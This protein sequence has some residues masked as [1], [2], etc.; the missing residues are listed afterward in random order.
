M[1]TRTAEEPRRESPR[2]A[3]NNAE[4]PAPAAEPPAAAVAAAAAAGASP[5]ARPMD[6]EHDGKEPHNSNDE[7]DE[8]MGDDNDNDNDEEE[9]DNDNDNDKE[10]E[11]DMGPEEEEEEEEEELTTRKKTRLKGGCP[12][13]LG[14]LRSADGKPIVV[15]VRDALAEQYEG[16]AYEEVPERPEEK[17]LRE[18]REQREALAQ[19]LEREGKNKEQGGAEDAKR[20]DKQELEAQRRL[21]QQ[22]GWGM[23]GIGESRLQ[24]V[25][26]SLEQRLNRTSMACDPT[27]YYRELRQG[28]VNKVD[29]DFIDDSEQVHELGFDL[30]AE[31]E[32]AEKDRRERAEKNGN[33]DNG[34]GQDNDDDEGTHSETDEELLYDPSDFIFRQGSSDEESDSEKAAADDFQRDIDS[35]GQLTVPLWQ[36]FQQIDRMPFSTPTVQAFFADL[37]RDLQALE[38]TRDHLQHI[39]QKFGALAEAVL[40]ETDVSVLALH[41]DKAGKSPARINVWRNLFHAV[42]HMCPDIKKRQFDRLWRIDYLSEKIKMG[43]VF[44]EECEQHILSSEL[45][46]DDPTHRLEL[47]QAFDDFRLRQQAATANAKAA[48]EAPPPHRPEGQGEGEASPPAAAAPAG[49]AGAGDGPVPMEIDGAASPE[50]SPS[51]RQDEASPQGSPTAAFPQTPTAAANKKRKEPALTASPLQCI[52]QW[53]VKLELIHRIIKD[54]Y[55]ALEGEDSREAARLQLEADAKGTFMQYLKKLLEPLG[56]MTDRPF[57][58]TNAMLKEHVQFLKKQFP[59]P[60]PARPKAKA[61][62]RTVRQGSRAAVGKR[63]HSGDDVLP[64]PAHDWRHVTLPS[65]AP[66]LPLTLPMQVEIDVVLTD[67][68]QEAKLTDVWLTSLT[69]SCDDVQVI[70]KDEQWC[71]GRPPETFDSLQEAYTAIQGAFRGVRGV[72]LALPDAIQPWKAFR[73]GGFPHWPLFDVCVLADLRHHGDDSQTDQQN[74]V[75]TRHELTGVPFVH[76]DGDTGPVMKLQLPRRVSGGG[77]GVGRPVPAKKHKKDWPAASG[78]YEE[79]PPFDPQ[80]FVPVGPVESLSST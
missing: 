31:F 64:G 20:A 80:D 42:K 36:H 13:Y 78:Q 38:D 27:S 75:L 50:P 48:P 71:K 19:Q 14:P 28:R 24:D 55:T 51:P 73:L 4:H 58:L 3:G 1:W 53:V 5:E 15:S 10:E 6:V 35:L 66:L 57:A 47:R 8:D 49:A 22:E 61:K 63:T 62:A 44:R 32:E 34:G 60:K 46:G 56:K 29:R 74:I 54:A 41:W 26:A 79:E 7:E 16:G 59:P 33:K 37:S 40:H 43:R 11:V 70:V 67:G 68:G 2:D 18:L 23:F 12:V 25:I 21:M 52:G 17:K 30:R 65:V 45:F 9:D 72:D 69:A 76:K 39:K 77:G